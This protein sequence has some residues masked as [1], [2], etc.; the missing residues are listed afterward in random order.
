[1]QR[2]EKAKSVP[3]SPAKICR[4]NEGWPFTCGEC[5]FWAEI[6]M[7]AVAIV[8]APRQGFCFGS[9]PQMVPVM[10]Q[11]KIVG[12]MNMRPQLPS[13]EQACSAFKVKARVAFGSPAN[14]GAN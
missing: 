1:M 9:P 11:G 7:A 2:D 14:K 12:A 4:T 13:T 5:I 10:N 3:N 8:G 6:E